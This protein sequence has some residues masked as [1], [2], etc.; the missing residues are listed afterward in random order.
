MNAWEG[1]LQMNP[2][3]YRCTWPGALPALDQG[4][5][6]YITVTT[7]KD[8]APLHR[9]LAAEAYTPDLIFSDETHDYWRFQHPDGV[10][11]CLP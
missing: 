11:P 7:P 10:R 3:G 8:Q 1:E 2:D 5:L 6:I 4:Y 9:R